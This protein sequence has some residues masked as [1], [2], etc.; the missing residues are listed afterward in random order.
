MSGVTAS[1]AGRRTLSAERSSTSHF[2]NARFATTARSWADF[3]PARGPSARARFFLLVLPPVLVR[4]L[5]LLL[6]LLVFF[7]AAMAPSA[8]LSPAEAETSVLPQYLHLDRPTF[9]ARLPVG[10][11]VDVIQLGR[12][13]GFDR[14]LAALVMPPERAV[15]GPAE[16]AVRRHGRRVVRARATDERERAAPERRQRDRRFRH[17]RTEW[18]PV[19]VERGGIHDQGAPAATREDDPAFRVREVS[20][21]E[22]FDDA[23]VV[24]S[25]ERSGVRVRSVK[26]EVHDVARGLVRSDS[27]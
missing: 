17:A 19:G 8:Q 26:H 24:L 1:A 20:E 18:L 16:V 23:V 15:H 5:L 25:P 13:Q 6:L 21:I 9:G 2:G 4:L 7:W 22:R 10:H 11:L 3:L 27:R 12:E 14:G